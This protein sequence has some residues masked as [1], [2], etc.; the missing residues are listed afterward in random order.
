[1]QKGE[2]IVVIFKYTWNFKF[3]E[4]TQELFKNSNN[5]SALQIVLSLLPSQML[6]L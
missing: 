2:I 1:M 5:K 3:S 6:G 4:K